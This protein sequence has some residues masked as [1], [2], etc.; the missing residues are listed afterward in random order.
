MISMANLVVRSAV[1]LSIILLIAPSGSS[2]K[3]IG[4]IAGFILII[5]IF[6]GGQ[7]ISFDL[8]ELNTSGVEEKR[9][10]YAEG[11]ESSL[12]QSIAD[13]IRTEAVAILQDKYPADEISVYVYIED[14]KLVVRLSQAVANMSDFEREL[15][16]RLGIPIEVVILSDTA[17]EE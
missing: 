6:T 7:S 15:E 13:K 2:K 11:L 12:V 8:P 4:I 9:Q 10:E 1:L 16:A 3:H 17:K 14:E 5:S